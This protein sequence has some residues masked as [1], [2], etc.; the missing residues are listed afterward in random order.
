MEDWKIS[1]KHWGNGH[2]ELKAEAPNKMPVY[3]RNV[4]DLFEKVKEAVD[5]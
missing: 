3:A 4:Q 1:I 5:Q 2:C